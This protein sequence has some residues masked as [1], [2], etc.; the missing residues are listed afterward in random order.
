[1]NRPQ[2]KICG[3]T[4]PEDA[5]IAE[6]AGASYVGAIL[7]PESPRFVEPEGA[8]RIARSVRIPLVAVAGETDATRLAQMAE[9]SGSG[10]VQLHGEVTPETVGFLREAGDWEL[11]KAVRVRSGTDITDAFAEFGSSV[12]LF[13]LDGWHE[14][15]LGGT[16]MTFPWETLETVRGSLPVGVRLGVAGGL[17]VENVRS[18]VERLD[19]DL[20]DV[21]SGVESEPGRKDLRRVREFVKRAIRAEIRRR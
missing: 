11:W 4:R 8:E 16:G 5:R 18:A 15:K 9:R 14:D 7:V 13:L 12:D 19:P 6:Q 1:M 3:V 20:V 2:V 17:S 21:S 10:A